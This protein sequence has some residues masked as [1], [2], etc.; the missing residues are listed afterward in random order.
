MLDIDEGH[1]RVSDDRGQITF[2]DAMFGPSQ[3]VTASKDNHSTSSMVDFD[4]RNVTLFLISY[5]PA[6]PGGGGGGIVT[7]RA[8][9][10]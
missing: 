7:R 2:S 10:A 4:A 6:E 5:Q 9:R 1:F 3:M 8:P